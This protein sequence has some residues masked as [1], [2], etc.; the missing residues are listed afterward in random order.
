MIPGYED[1]GV[2]YGF[3]INAYFKKMSELFSRKEIEDLADFLEAL[4]G[5]ENPER[6][7]G[8]I[9]AFSRLN[10]DDEDDDEC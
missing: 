10:E 6:R 7:E 1:P 2:R 8:F 9:E 3:S 5:E 4:S